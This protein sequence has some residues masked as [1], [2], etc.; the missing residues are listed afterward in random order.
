MLARRQ[1]MF[2]AVLAASVAAVSTTPVAGG[3]TLPAL[4]VIDTGYLDRGA[5]ACVDFFQFANGGWLK[6]DT[7][8]AAYSTSGVSRDMSDRN[9][10]VVRQVLDD[11]VARRASLP[12]RST[13]R[14][15]G[16]FYATCMDSAAADRQGV[17]PVKP[18]LASI[19]RVNTP[20]ALLHEMAKLHVM[21]TDAGFRYGAD[22]DI[23]D[24]AHYLA[25][26]DRG[27]LGL[28]DRDYYLKTDPASDS[29][30]TAYVEHVARLLTLSGETE[31]AARDEARRIL[32]LET[33]LARAE[34]ARVARRDPSAVDHP[35]TLAGLNTLAPGMDWASYFHDVGITTTPSRINVAEPEYFKRLNA[36]MASTPLD[37]WRAFLRFHALEQAAPWLSSAFVQED[38]TFSTRFTGAKTILPRWKRCLEVTDGVI[39]EALGQAYVART[40]PP[41]AR[42]RAKALIDDIRASFG[43]R[44]AA[45]DWMSAATKK[46]AQN[47]LALMSEKVGYPD[48]WRDYSRLEVDSGSF[49]LNLQ[50]ARAFESRRT[51]NRPGAKVDLNEWE[52][53]VPTVNAYYNPTKNEMVFPSG[54][55]APQT[56]DARADDAANYGSLGGSW[57]GHELTHGFDDEGRH[58]DAKG[59]LRDWWSSSD[60]AH[61]AV[62]AQ[63]VSDQFDAYIQIDTFHVNGKLTLGENIAD[64]GGALTA[65]D[66]LQLALKRN[67]RPGLIE[68]FTPEQ[69]FFLS[70]AQS[71]RTHSR[72]ESMRSRVRVDPHAPSQWR[73]NG[74]LSSMTAFAT[75]FGCK[76][77]DPM[78]RS[79][80]LV[81]HIW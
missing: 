1:S 34:L 53:T 37:D 64:Y 65:Y 10:L 62:E 5:N 77:G 71:W 56:F 28:P 26:F 15:L 46:Q 74:P 35:M 12:A 38:F 42:L 31:T 43:R 16:T 45:L 29:L 4:K 72:P 78:V 18:A 44:V 13:T 69:R 39:G 73:T 63:K 6:R 3:Q 11:A 30:R 24:A 19:N 80:A 2:V 48:T 52:M 17:D 54:A 50:R 60:S 76:A 25:S 27:A 32:A 57:A 59:N 70:Y 40:F 7:I 68:G 47:K 33:E 22:V 49:V 23:H 81:P 58:F 75:A 61:F 14:K 36:L 79:A 8:P 66:A 9:Q 21:G 55:L 41:S 20:A 51:F 67:G